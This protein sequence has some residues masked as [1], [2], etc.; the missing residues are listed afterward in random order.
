VRLQ[1]AAGN[2]SGNTNI[3]KSDSKSPSPLVFRSAKVEEKE[4]GKTDGKQS[5]NEEDEG[6]VRLASS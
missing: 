2:S 1:V 5:A 6:Q 4:E 3:K